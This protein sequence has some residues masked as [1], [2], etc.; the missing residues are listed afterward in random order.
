MSHSTRAQRKIVAG[1]WSARAAARVLASAALAFAAGCGT[2]RMTDTL[3]TATEQLLVSNA[4]D[5]AVSEMDFRALCGKT[6][7]FDPQYLEGTVDRGYLISS[8]RQQLLACGCLLQD[9]RT[10]ADYVVEVRSGGVGTDRHALLVGV[11]QMNVP[12]FVPGQPSQIPEIPLA[13]KT[14]QEGVAKIAVFA[15]NRQTGKPV[16]QSGAVEAQSTSRDTWVLGAGPFQWGTIRKGAE[17]AGEPILPGGERKKADDD[18]GAAE[19]SVTEEATWLDTLT[20]RTDSKRLASLLGAVPLS[21]RPTSAD[22]ATPSFPIAAPAAAKSDPPKPTPP[23]AK[24]GL[25]PLPPNV[26]GQAETEPSIVVRTG[27]G[28]PGGAPVLAPTAPFVP[29][30]TTNPTETEPGVVLDSSVGFQPDN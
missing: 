11:P 15:Y 17:F 24:P 14:D 1:S 12:T 22:G 3:R 18:G 20:P 25:T 23:A 2:T 7:F 4:I 21:E 8:L 13:K 27:L 26:G 29:T 5:Q 28:G 10:K 19:L 6:V 30:P 16:W 9:D